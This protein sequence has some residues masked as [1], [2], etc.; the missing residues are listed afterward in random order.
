[1]QQV[2]LVLVLVLVSTNLKVQKVPVYHK[3]RGMYTAIAKT[4]AGFVQKNES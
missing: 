1:M 3:K 2:N 4:G